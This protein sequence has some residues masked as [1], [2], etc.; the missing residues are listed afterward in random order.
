LLGLLALSPL[1]IFVLVKFRAR[2]R[3]RRDEESR[4]LAEAERLRAEELASRA[5]T[6][7]DIDNMTG[8]QLEL[9]LERVF[10][11]LVSRFSTPEK[12]ETKGRT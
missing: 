5:I 2:A 8:Q 12:A 1:A 11:Y 9:Y 3:R 6:E 7:S 4:R 10:Q